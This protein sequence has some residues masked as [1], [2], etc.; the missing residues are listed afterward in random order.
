MFYRMA[1]FF[2]ICYITTNYP[3]CRLRV[4]HPQDGSVPRPTRRPMPRQRRQ[5]DEKRLETDDPR[6]STTDIGQN[7]SVPPLIRY[8]HLGALCINLKGFGKLVY[9]LFWRWSFESDATILTLTRD[10]SVASSFI[11][12]PWTCRALVFYFLKGHSH[13]PQVRGT[14]MRKIINLC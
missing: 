9:S 6:R 10:E 3:S 8:L 11:F 1:L 12:K 4:Q 13:F 5:E 14:T 2:L 7:E